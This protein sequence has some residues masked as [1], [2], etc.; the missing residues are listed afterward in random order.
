MI[1]PDPGTLHAAVAVAG[2]LTIDAAIGD[3]AAPWHPVRLLGRLAAGAESVAR[4]IWKAPVAQDRTEVGPRGLATR[5]VLAGASAWLAVVAAAG[6]FALALGRAAGVLHPMA[7]LAVDMLIVWASVA[8]ADLAAHAAR[9]RRALEAAER[10]ESGALERSRAAVSMLVGRD[11]S[12]LDASGVARACVE[13]VAES[14]IDGAAA[15]LFWAALLG[16]AGAAAYRAV[17]TMDSMFGHKDERYL[18]FGLVPARADDVANWLPARLS[19]A[20]ACVLAPVAGGSPR[21]AFDSF[22]RWRLSHESPNAGHPEAAY[23]GA[24]GLRLGGPSRYAEGIIDKPWI[25]PTGA[26]ATSAHVSRAVRLMYAQVLLSATAFL[27]LRIALGTL[28]SFALAA[29]VA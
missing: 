5:A 27:S 12:A 8:P 15:P 28:L 2:G 14:S 23:A 10:G 18:F 26:E 29:I 3:P 11:V 6:G 25:N 21:A 22:A 24:L 9:V 20:L 1:A 19:S 7:G 13:S 4:R 17:N 16:P